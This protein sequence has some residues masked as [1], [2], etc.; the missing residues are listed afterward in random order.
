MKN[1]VF[2][3]KIRDHEGLFGCLRFGLFS[4]LVLVPILLFSG[5]GEA[6][7]EMS[8]D[9]AEPEEKDISGEALSVGVDEDFIYVYVCGQV[10]RPGVYP[11]SGNCRVYEALALAGG[12]KEAAD[13]SALNQAEKLSDG[14]KI[15]VPSVEEMQRKAENG[16]LSYGDTVNAGLSAAGGEG[17]D[18]GKAGGGLVNINTA[19]KAALMT[20][21]GIGQT[22]AQS[23]IE[24]RQQNGNFKKIE[25]IMNVPGI[26]EGLFG[27]ISGQIRVD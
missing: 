11:V 8:L 27:K 12:I 2:V 4:I 3:Q 25:D 17:A 20:I 22:R 26:K 23:I 9:I 14:L 7:T 18:S 1:S 5:C 6:D 16:E 13:I 21:N 15:Y 10:M 24:Y 19:D